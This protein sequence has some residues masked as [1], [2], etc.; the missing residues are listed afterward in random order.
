MMN[1]GN[2]IESWNFFTWFLACY[3]GWRT[4]RWKQRSDL[5]DFTHKVICCLMWVFAGLGLSAF[6]FAMSRF[7]HLPDG[8]PWNIFMYE[9]RWT[10]VTTT[11]LMIGWGGISFAMLIDESS[12]LKKYSVFAA[13]AVAAFGL[14]FY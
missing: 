11:K 4:F 12:A 2:V 13:A 7:L 6:W 8:N 5:D 14:G 1:T 9:W 10:V 3:V